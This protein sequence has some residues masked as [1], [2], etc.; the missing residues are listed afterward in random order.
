MPS[1]SLTEHDE[2]DVF[3]LEL[4]GELDV[5]TVGGVQRDVIE[6]V[7]THPCLVLDGMGL[8]FIDSSGMRLLLSALRIV[9]R[10]KGCFVFACANPTVLRLFAVTGMDQTFDLASSREDAMRV[11]RE[12]SQAA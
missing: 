9:G 7:E 3:V 8:T 4:N 6:A 1:L 11:A 5:S 2:G 12:A 10:R